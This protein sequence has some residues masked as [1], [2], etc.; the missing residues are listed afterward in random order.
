MESDLH[1]EKTFCEIITLPYWTI[2]RSEHRAQKLGKAS[3]VGNLSCIN[4]QY[5]V[6]PEKK[7]AELS[8]LAMR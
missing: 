5:S 1:L 2:A 3:G 7:H 6:I 4:Q 8:P